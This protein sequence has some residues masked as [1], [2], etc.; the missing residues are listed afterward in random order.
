MEATNFKLISYFHFK[1]TSR[2]SNQ[3]QLLVVKCNPTVIFLH[4][5]N[6]SFAVRVVFLPS[7]SLCIIEKLRD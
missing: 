1:R 6:Q 4:S 3:K 5:K 2:T 7:L